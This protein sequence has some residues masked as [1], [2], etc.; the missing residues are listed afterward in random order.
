MKE[1]S[2]EPGQIRMSSVIGS[3]TQ[4]V[5]RA[6]LAGLRRGKVVASPVQKRKLTLKQ[7][8]STVTRKNVHTE[9]E[10]GTAAGRE[11]R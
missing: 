4:V 11:I 9:I 1:I 6:E 7:L 3:G 8:L 5:N 10:Y 2:C